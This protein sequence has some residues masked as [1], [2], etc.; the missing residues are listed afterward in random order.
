MKRK[1]KCGLL[2]NFFV[3]LKE[4]ILCL[5]SQLLITFYLI[6]P[7]SCML[8]DCFDSKKRGRSKFRQCSWKSSSLPFWR[9]QKSSR[10]GRPTISFFGKTPR[11]GGISLSVHMV[12]VCQ[13]DF[14][15][16]PTQPQNIGEISIPN[17]RI[18]IRFKTWF[19]CKTTEQF[20]SSE[21]E[22]YQILYLDLTGSGS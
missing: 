7:A 12:G 11:G 15:F 4:V 22:P 5:I 3:D 13:K 8:H 18:Q 14:C 19:H 9:L 17:Y 1:E 20:F 16:N 6:F 10:H 2:S 21:I